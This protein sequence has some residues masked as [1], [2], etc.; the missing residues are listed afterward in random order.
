M[1]DGKSVM[2]AV[3]NSG[4]PIPRASLPYLFDRFYK[5][6]ESHTRTKEGTGIGLSIVKTILEEHRQKIWVESDTMGGTTFS[7]TLSRP[8][9]D[10]QEHAE[11]SAKLSRNRE[12]RR[13]ERRDSSARQDSGKRKA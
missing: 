8:H 5:G 10:A 11:G 13:K 3:N 2:I 4:E 7:F 12:S 9:S 1:N 6:D